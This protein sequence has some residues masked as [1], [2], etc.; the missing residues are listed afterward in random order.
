MEGHKVVHDRYS[1]ATQWGRLESLISNGKYSANILT[2]HES[3]ELPA[4]RHADRI[5]SLCF[6][7]GMID[8]VVDGESFVA[9]EGTSIDISPRTAHS[10]HSLSKSVVVSVWSPVGALPESKPYRVYAW[11]FHKKP[12]GGEMWLINN[13]YHAAKIMSVNKGEAF[14]LQFHKKKH[15]TFYFMDGKAELVYDG[16]QLIVGPSMI[17][18]IPPNTNHRITAL[19]KVIF[20][21]VSTA[22]LD[23]VVRIEDKYNR[24]VSGKEERK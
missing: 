14:S 9:R 20:L 12:W 11:E 23:D 21:E 24:P 3:Q 7:K 6:M 1:H 4:E 18:D 13:G 19:E 17:V 10:M 16:S 15:E 2:I 8:C 5:E 22:E